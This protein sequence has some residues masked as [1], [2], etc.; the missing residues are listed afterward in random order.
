MAPGPSREGVAT[1]TYR[2]LLCGGL[3]QIPLFLLQPDLLV[4]ERDIVFFEAGLPGAAW[5]SL[6][7]SAVVRCGDIATIK[8]LDACCLELRLWMEC[9][10]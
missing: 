5:P 2:S 4:C 6:H 3:S 8:R 10:L 7:L 1:L 9:G